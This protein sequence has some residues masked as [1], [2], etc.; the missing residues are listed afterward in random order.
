MIGEG[1]GPRTRGGRY[2]SMGP[3][4]TPYHTGRNG[5]RWLHPEPQWGAV[6]GNWFLQLVYSLQTVQAS[7][8]LPALIVRHLP[9]RVA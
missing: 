6:Q 1:V 9:S 4:S 5:C 2:F 7:T 3:V 8:Q